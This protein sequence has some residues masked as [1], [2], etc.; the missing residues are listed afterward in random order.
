MAVPK[1]KTTKSRRNMRRAHSWS[2]ALG[3]FFGPPDW[4]PARLRSPGA[5]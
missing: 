1:K 4:Q 5:R 2:E 3:Y